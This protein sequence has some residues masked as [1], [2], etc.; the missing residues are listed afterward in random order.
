MG[1]ET[2]LEREQFLDVFEKEKENRMFLLKMRTKVWKIL[3]NTKGHLRIQ[4]FM[5]LDSM[6][7]L[8]TMQRNIVEEYK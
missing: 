1:Q 2:N 4:S 5:C 6:S 7:I 8:R 3:I